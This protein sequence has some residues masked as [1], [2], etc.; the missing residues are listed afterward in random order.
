M[1][2]LTDHPDMT[3]HVVAYSGCKTTTDFH[4]GIRRSWR[5]EGVNI[6]YSGELYT[7]DGI[8]DLEYTYGCIQQAL[9]QTYI[10]CNFFAYCIILV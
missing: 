5:G 1:V 6:P 9:Q 8:L 3:I 7:R 2:R 10:S 4:T